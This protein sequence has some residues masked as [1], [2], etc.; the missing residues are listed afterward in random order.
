MKLDVKAVTVALA[1]VWGVL[2]MFAIGVMNIILQGYGGQFLAMM[3]AVYPGYR[4]TAGFP[5]VLVGTL[6]GLLHGAF[7][8]AAYAWL[9]NRFAARRAA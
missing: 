4:V 6:Y 3:Q 9:Y 1:L 2:G 7:M 8:G 5:G